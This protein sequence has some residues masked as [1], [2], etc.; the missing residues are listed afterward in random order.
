MLLGP[1][2]SRRAGQRF[3]T[4]IVQP[5]QEDLAFVV[6][7]LES[8]AIVPVIDRSYPLSEVADAIRYMEAGQARGKI[9]ITV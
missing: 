7:L 4:F 9:V 3:R 8:G 6:D 1:W 2:R 5:R